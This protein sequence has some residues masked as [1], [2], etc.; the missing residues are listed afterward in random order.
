M[1]RPKTT[2]EAA[3][4]DLPFVLAQLFSHAI[5]SQRIYSTRI[6]V[7]RF[8]SRQPQPPRQ[9]CGWTDC[10]PSASFRVFRS[11]ADV[12]RDYYFET[13][14]VHQTP[15]SS[16]HASSTPVCSSINAQI[17]LRLGLSIQ[18]APSPHHLHHHHPLIFRPR[19]SQRPSWGGAPRGCWEARPPPRWS[20]APAAC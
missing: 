17:N 15:K 14:N 12:R 5:Q 6:A 11:I 7:P 19:A 2:T 3:G 20:R 18:V 16:T 8:Q 4:C 13:K 10:N 9:S 1:T